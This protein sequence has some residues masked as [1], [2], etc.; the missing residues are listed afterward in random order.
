MAEFT[1]PPA[2]D[3]VKRSRS[4]GYPSFALPEAIRKAELLYRHDKRNPV[5]AQ[6]A[7]EHWGYSPTSSA[8][9]LSVA[10]L[11]K[12]GLLEEVE[13]GASRLV[14]L[15]DRALHILLSEDGSSDRAKAV[16]EA[17]L[18]PPI[19]A[20]LWQQYGLDLPSDANLKRI[21]I[22]ERGFADAAANDLIRE[23][24]ETISFAGVRPEAKMGE[25]ESRREPEEPTQM[26]T[27]APPIHNNPRH[28]AGPEKPQNLR[29]YAFPM[30][31]APDAELFLPA[32]MSED[33]YETLKE[34]LASFLAMSR[35]ALVAKNPIRQPDAGP[36][37]D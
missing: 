12:F 37:G 10:T 20:D 29:R 23:Y 13:G 27:A 8:V 31:D 11:K 9:L 30:E 1:A 18:A 32:P 22:M 14:R 3:R 19:H 33:N 6:I 17:A 28:A 5:P 34:M 7:A 15:T 26:T 35:R 16:R 21:L 24:R 2:S 25:S 4:P 36:D